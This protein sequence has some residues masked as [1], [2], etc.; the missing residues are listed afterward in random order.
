MVIAVIICTGGQFLAADIAVV[1]LSGLIGVR[2][3]GSL[4]DLAAGT[5]APVVIFIEP[6]VVMCANM[7]IGLAK[8]AQIVAIFIYAILNFRGDRCATLAGNNVSML[9]AAIGRIGSSQTIVGVLIG[10]GIAGNSNGHCLLCDPFLGKGGRIGNSVRRLAIR[11]CHHSG[12]L[13]RFGIGY[14]AGAGASNG[15][16]R[17]IIAP[18][19]LAG[20]I[21]VSSCRNGFCFCFATN[22]TSQQSDASFCA[23]GI[24]CNC[25][26]IPCMGMLTSGTI[27]LR[28][29]PLAIGV[30]HGQR[31]TLRSLFRE[32]ISTVRIFKFRRG[33]RDFRITTCRITGLCHLIGCILRTNLY[34]YHT[35]SFTADNVCAT[36]CRI[37]TTTASIHNAVYINQGIFQIRF[38]A[39][40]ASTGR[41]GYRQELIVLRRAILTPFVSIINVDIISFAKGAGYAI[42]YNN[43]CARQQS[44]ILVDRQITSMSSQCNVAIDR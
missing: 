39:V 22:G 15:A 5:N 30:S 35:G 43:F 44:N 23:A 4:H 8:I 31:T 16:R 24:F 12:S 6:I 42:F 10:I 28:A 38:C 17:L 11:L 19:R 7:Q 18:N 29:D 33:D 14:T 36:G 20:N 26:F 37:N 9:A 40:V 3:G 34:G 25:S 21:G 32:H 2:S 27:K 13:H 1:I 41:V